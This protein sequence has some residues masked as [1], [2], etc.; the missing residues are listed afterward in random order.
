[1][2]KELAQLL[3]QHRSARLAS[4]EDPAAALAQSLRERL[5]VG[6]LAGAVDALESDET[7][8]HWVPDL[9]W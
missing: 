2:E 8:A 7:A 5:D 4:A 3:G 9:R 6:R 1:M